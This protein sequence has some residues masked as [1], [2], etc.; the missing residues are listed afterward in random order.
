MAEREVHFRKKDLAEV[1]LGACALGFPVAATDEIVAL[2]QN[3]SVTRILMF[4]AAGILVLAAFGFFMHGPEMIRAHRGA[5]VRRIIVIYG[6]T[7]LISAG[8]LW[9]IDSFPLLDE[10]TVALR[11]AILVAFPASFAGTIVNGLR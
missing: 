6:V 10:P 3:L 8:M 9:A 11:R 2:S 5:F 4:A 7:L 1:A